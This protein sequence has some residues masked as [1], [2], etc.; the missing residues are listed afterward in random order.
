M[1]RQHTKEFHSAKH[2]ALRGPRAQWLGGLNEAR[3]VNQRLSPSYRTVICAL[4]TAYAALV[5]L[6]SWH[7]VRGEG[8]GWYDREVLLQ[9]FELGQYT[10][11]YVGGWIDL[12]QN[13][14]AW[15]MAVDNLA[16]HLGGFESTL[17]VLTFVV[18]AIYAAAS[19]STSMWLF[20][21]LFM[22]IQVDLFD[23]QIRSACAGALLVVAYRSDRVAITVLLA[24]IA[25]LF[26]AAAI[27]LLGLWLAATVVV[28]ICERG[29]KARSR[30]LAAGFLSS[31][32]AMI[33][34]W[35][36]VLN[37]NRTEIYSVS[38]VL[39]C[40]LLLAV[41]TAA[42]RGQRLTPQT[43]FSLMLLLFVGVGGTLGL[44]TQR[45]LPLAMPVLAATFLGFRAP[46]R[47]ISA[48]LVLVA[49]TYW[50]VR[51]LGG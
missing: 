24:L 19:L 30:Q 9:S 26:H 16:A 17:V 20:P 43:L 34:I 25:M 35:V 48:L 46:Y 32:S 2:V 45:L 51:W 40:M 41:G 14:S 27:L 5:A 22:P 8:A 4:A 47:T 37:D 3:T 44:G 13:W 36:C 12:F 10:Y 33:L 28:R 21:L 23:S 1:R 49:Q 39:F 11:L 38:V 42:T 6:V 18:A 31:V 15:Y 29:P 7:L 50:T